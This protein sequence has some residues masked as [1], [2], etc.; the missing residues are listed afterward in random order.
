MDGAFAEAVRAIVGPDVPIGGIC[1]DMHGNVSKRAGR[2]STDVTSS[3]APTRTSIPSRAAA[4]A[5]SSCSATATRRDP[6]A[7]S[8]SRRRRWS[9][10]SSASSP[11]EEPMSRSSPTASRPT[12]GR[13]SSTRAW[14]RATRT[15]T[16]RRWAWPGSRSPTATSM[17]RGMPPSG[18]PS[19]GWAQREALNQPASLDRG[20]ARPRRC[21]LPRPAAA[22]RRRPGARPTA[23]RSRRRGPRP[24]TPAIARRGAGPIVLMD[25][26]D[27]IGGG[28]SADSTH[29]LARGAAARDRR[30]CSR[31]S[32]TPRRSR[33]RVAPGVGAEVTL[34]RRRQDGRPARRAGGRDR[35]GPRRSSTAVGGPGRHAR[36]H[37]ILRRRD[38]GPHRHDRRPHA[39]A[40]LEAGRQHLALADVL[41]RDPARDLPDR[42]RQGRPSRRGRPTSR[43]RAR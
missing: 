13:A 17:R 10:T 42:R 29:I 41:R 37:P 7:S 11:A 8:G 30:R 24:R 27:N 33:P 14:P 9:S 5:P 39:A 19:R 16:S 3:G 40:H 6:A 35:H 43:S 1:L 15:P 25:V 26:G 23:R 38:V 34:A 22:R 18:W 36:R 28:S 21:A 32:T 2:R 4:S 20:G 12:S 31:R